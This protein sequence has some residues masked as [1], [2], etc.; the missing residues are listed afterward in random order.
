[1][2]L[3]PDDAT[4]HGG[5]RAFTTWERWTTPR[6]PLMLVALLLAAA[7]PLLA[8]RGA[9]FA[10]SLMAS[11]ALVLLFFPIAS[12]AYDYRF[13]IPAIGPLV[14]AAALAAWG[15]SARLAPG[16]HRQGVS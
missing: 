10:A 8:P 9:R 14:A 13:V 16:S 2:L 5:V 6:G 1:M 4:H 12:K 15:L 3:Y 11:T 7:S